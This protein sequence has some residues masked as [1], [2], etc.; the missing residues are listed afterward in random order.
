MA[1]L[2]VVPGLGD[3]GPP[4]T[5][6]QFVAVQ[7]RLADIHT[8]VGRPLPNIVHGDLEPTQCAGAGINHQTHTGLF[9][10]V[11]PP[12]PQPEE[13][14]EMVI[15]TVGNWPKDNYAAFRQT[16]SGVVSW[17]VDGNELAAWQRDGA[18]IA[19]LTKDAFGSTVD[20]GRTLGSISDEVTRITG[21]TRDRWLGRAVA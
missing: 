7:R 9:L 3:A 13:D 6:A 19:H 18:E 20:Y 14:T 5:P 16:A 2:L 11:T 12:T 21:V 1:L 17:I 15:I 10:P 8:R 4:A